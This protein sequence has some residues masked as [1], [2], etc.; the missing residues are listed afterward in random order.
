LLAT[1]GVQMQQRPARSGVDRRD[2]MSRKQRQLSRGVALGVRTSNDGG[3]LKLSQV[4]AGGAAQKAG[5]AAGD[6]VMAVDGLR[7][8][9]DNVDAH[10]AR[11]SAGE[12]VEVHAFRR[13]ELHVLPVK[14][15]AAQLDAWSLSVDEDSSE[16]AR[17]RRAWLGPARAGAS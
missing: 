3:E 9:P 14:L 15:E 11:Y 16:G 5:L 12:T 17:A 2:Q 13:D 6:I 7:V 10:L 8:T 1:V 4:F